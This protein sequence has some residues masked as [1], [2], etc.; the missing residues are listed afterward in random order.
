[1]TELSFRLPHERLRPFLK[2]YFYGRDP[3]PP[4]VQRIVPNGEM[5]LCFYR[6]DRVDY[7]GCGPVVSCLSGQS[8]RWQDI[9]A[10]GGI[11]IVGAHFTTL[12]A[13]LFFQAPLH[14]YFGRAVPLS[15]LSDP[16][17][18]ELE[19]RVLSA[20]GP[21][22]AWAAMDAF[23]LRR[24]DGAAPDILTLRRLYRALAYSRLHVSGLR[25]GDIASEACLSERQFSRL[26]AEN[27]GLSPKDYLRLQRYH[28]TLHDL[29]SS[30]PGT[31]TLTEVAWRN[32]YYDFS[33][34][35]TDFRKISGY[36]P[37]SLLEVS[38]NDGDPAGWRI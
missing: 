17:L 31:A 29:K 11:E 7:A 16:S 18:L 30:L 2:M 20:P 12:G 33:H 25:V 34:L 5:G 8:V 26:F 38:A 4:A 6:G 28:R 32:G 14:E 22:Q 24:V 3:A 9:L 37:S 19:D 10:T 15:D 1:M 21:L 13:G 27:V 23:F 35:T 36:A